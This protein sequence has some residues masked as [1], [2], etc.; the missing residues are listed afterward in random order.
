MKAFFK[1]N[2]F[3]LLIAA[4]L[5]F[6]ILVPGPGLAVKKVTNITLYLTFI[7][8]FASG[9]GLSLDNIK[10]GLKDWKSILY[11]FMSVYL[12]F[13][14]V[15]LAVM[16]IIGKSN[17]DIFVGSMIM[18]A[19][20]TTLASAVVLTS[21]ANG[22]VPLALI[23]TIINNMSSAV[24]TPLVLK[25][26]LSL[27]EP[28]SFDVGTMII[29]LLLA[30]VLPVVL[31]QLL[32]KVLK[33]RV[34][35]ISPYR[36]VI[37]KFV[38]LIIVLTGASAASERIRDSFITAF[39]I[40]LLVAVLHVIMLLISSLY[41]KLSKAKPETKPAVLFTSTQ[42]T[43]PSALLIWESYFPVYAA[44]PL[45]IVLNHIV[46]IFIDSF[47]VNKLGRRNKNDKQE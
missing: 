33:D 47:V 8:M 15:T 32:R 1:N 28:V 18:A 7:A 41:L 9:L 22:N 24:V 17:G 19:Q 31:A 20:S 2:L 36:K 12:I 3:I 10:D 40:I 44:A 37:S 43:M 46:Q 45:V 21:S 13:P 4:V 6:S 27:Q 5:V 14:A 42:K 39:L 30:L 38:V 26:V 11:S 34:N 35:K 23:I 29:K 25:A 16:L